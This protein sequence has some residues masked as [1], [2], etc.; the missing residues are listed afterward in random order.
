M[1]PAAKGAAHFIGGAW[2]E[3]RI[4]LEQAQLL[5]KIDPA[6]AESFQ[7]PRDAAAAAK[8][9]KLNREE[10]PLIRREGSTTAPH[11]TDR[12]L[13]AGRADDPEQ[14][15]ALVRSLNDDDP[16]IRQEVVTALSAAFRFPMRFRAL[17][18]SVVGDLIAATKRPETRVSA[19]ALAVLR[20][21]G[22]AA[23]EA[24]PTLLEITKNPPSPP[25]RVQAIYALGQ[26]GAAAVEAVPRLSQILTTDIE[27]IEPHE[28]SAAT[29]ALGLIGKA[30]KPAVPAFREALE[31]HLITSEDAEALYHIDPKAAEELKVPRRQ[32]G[33]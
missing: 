12:G 25:D 14:L 22:P 2:R 23:A 18:P 15:V 33:R 10:D 21:M 24:V 31:K 11:S 29:K 13:Q 19:S 16:I 3:H 17:P 30:A 4:T 1:G 6:A 28:R 9:Q 5:Y 32:A 26:I 27:P 8:L 20:Y 7:I